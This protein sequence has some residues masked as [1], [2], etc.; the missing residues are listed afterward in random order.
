MNLKNLIKFGAIHFGVLTIALFLRFSN[1]ENEDMNVAI[2]GTLIYLPYIIGLV[3]LNLGLLS[4][5]CIYFKDRLKPL[6]ILLAPLVLLAW[7][8]ISGEHLQVY[9]WKLSPAELW[10]LNLIVLFLNFRVI[11]ALKKQEDNE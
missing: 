6:A 10:Y 9:N 5:G 4:L 2:L 3:V 8:F 7:Y 1:K 11:M